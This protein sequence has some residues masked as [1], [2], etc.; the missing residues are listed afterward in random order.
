MAFTKTEWW[1]TAADGR[2]IGWMWPEDF[3]TILEVC[4]PNE[5]WVFAFAAEFGFSRSNVDRWRDGKLPIPKHVAHIVNM[6]SN[7]RTAK[8]P[9][10]R[11]KATWLPDG[12]GDIERPLYP[13]KVKKV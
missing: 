3:S 5:K 6:L 2:R 13:V 1:K 10:T 7:T 8:K 9:L 11:L 12:V 4:Y